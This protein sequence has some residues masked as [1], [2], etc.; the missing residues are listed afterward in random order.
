M[1]QQDKADNNN[2]ESDLVTPLK[3]PRRSTR[4][5]VQ[6]ENIISLSTTKYSFSKSTPFFTR[7]LFFCISKIKAPRGSFI[8]LHMFRGCPILLYIFCKWTSFLYIFVLFIIKIYI[9]IV[10]KERWKWTYEAVAIC[11]EAIREIWI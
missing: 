1:K 8:I 2:D 5:S 10:K 4:L 7:Y 9:C 6:E 3:T 11:I